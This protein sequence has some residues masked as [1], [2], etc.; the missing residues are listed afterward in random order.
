MGPSDISRAS[1]QRLEER[2]VTFDFKEGYIRVG[3][4]GSVK[5]DIRI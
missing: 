1:F 3:K 5:T 2:A 4:D